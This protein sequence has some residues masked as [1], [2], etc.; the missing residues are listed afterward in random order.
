VIHITGVHTSGGEG[1]EH[2]VAVR[3]ECP[4]GC[5]FGENVRAAIVDFIQNRGGDVRLRDELGNQVRVGVLGGDPP[6]LRAFADGT[7]T[8]DLLAVPRY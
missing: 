8:D 2:I 4:S 6:C 1:H 7:W 3:W 5:S